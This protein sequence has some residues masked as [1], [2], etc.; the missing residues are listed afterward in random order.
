MKFL[1]VTTIKKDAVKIWVCQETTPV[2][3]IHPPVDLASVAAT[4]KGLG[5]EAKILDMRLYNDP[6]GSYQ[7]EIKDYHPDAVILNLTTTSAMY[8]YQILTSTSPEIKKILFGTHAISMP[9]DVFDRGAADFILIGDPEA[10]IT[11]L[12]KNNFNGDISDGVLTKNIMKKAPLY[13]SAQQLDALP[14]PALDLIDFNNYRAPYMRGKY[15]I[16]LAA[17]GCPFLCT[18]CL[19]PTLF[20]KDARQRSAKS[21]V[22]EMQFNKEKFGITEYYFIDATFNIDAKHI[23]EICDEMIKRDLKIKW[24]CNMRVYPVTLEMMQKMKEAGCIRVFYGVEDPDVFREIKK[25]ANANQ[26]LNAFKVT[27]EAGVKT[28]AFT[29]VFDRKDVANEK[30][31]KEKTLQLLK[32]L[33]ADAFQCNV[34]IPFP[35]TE[36]YDTQSK[37]MPL[38]NDWSLYDPNGDKLPYDSK[39]NLVRIKKGIYLNFPIVNP[40]ATLKAISEMRPSSLIPLAKRVIALASK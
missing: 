6:M 35:G 8:D 36:L 38:S 5:H 1:L 28:V 14:F 26:T 24:S 3:S 20:G 21:I 2:G 9:K 32:Q 23:S 37:E 39:L 40:R 4:I 19:Y 29:M 31:Y 17:R 18:Y 22:D 15:S 27:K 33:D 30:V 7:N 25:G 11:N 12:I 13:L 10:G 16:M 34:A